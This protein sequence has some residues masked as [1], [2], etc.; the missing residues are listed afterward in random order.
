MKC[1]G[2]YHDAAV[3]IFRYSLRDHAAHMAF[4]KLLVLSLETVFISLR[5]LAQRS[6]VRV[7]CSSELFAVAAPFKGILPE[8][9]VRYA[10]QLFNLFIYGYFFILSGTFAVRFFIVPVLINALG[11][12]HLFFCFIR[13]S[14]KFFVVSEFNTGRKIYKARFD[15]LFLRPE[16]GLIF[17]RKFRE[18]IEHCLY[19]RFFRVCQDRCRQFCF[20]RH[21]SVHKTVQVRRSF[22]Q[23]KPRF[24]MLQQFPEIVCTYRR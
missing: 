20:F 17:R 23:Y 24:F 10:G 21:E 19:R 4:T 8:R 7:H 11:G 2:H 6:T 15:A 3:R 1:T 22:D 13:A 12:H 16:N 14:S 18:R 5:K 9:I